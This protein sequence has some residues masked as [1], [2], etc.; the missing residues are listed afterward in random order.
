[1]AV[2]QSVILKAGAQPLANYPHAKQ[3]GST[4]YL[5]GIS[6]RE[7]SGGVRGVTTSPDGTVLTDIKEQTRGVLEK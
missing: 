7:P 2:P 4:L 6:A 3:V 5:S 1:M